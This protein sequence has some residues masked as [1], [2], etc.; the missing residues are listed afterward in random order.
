[1]TALIGFLKSLEHQLV[2][3]P[4]TIDASNTQSSESKDTPSTAKNDDGDIVDYPS[5]E[6]DNGSSF[7]SFGRNV[8]SPITHG[9][10]PV[11]QG[12][13]EPMR[14]LLFGSDLDAVK[15]LIS[16]IDYPFGA[17]P[18]EVTQE[19][20]NLFSL[21]INQFVQF[22]C[23]K[24]KPVITADIKE[25]KA[26][27][28]EPKELVFVDAYKDAQIPKDVTNVQRQPLESSIFPLGRHLFKAATTAWTSATTL[29]HP[30]PAEKKGKET[31]SP[32]QPD[33]EE[34]F[35]VV[36]GADFGLLPKQTFAH[37]THFKPAAQPS[38]PIARPVAKPVKPT[39]VQPLGKLARQSA[40]PVS[41]TTPQPSNTTVKSRRVI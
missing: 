40:K 33:I 32:G 10:I 22:P 16:F 38:K 9:L 17:L 26:G 31:P 6:E 37:H 21:S 8:L 27:T 35:E 34:E 11:T 36:N 20:I 12:L 41:E 39:S 7:L 25:E 29:L 19:V 23:E 3:L 13:V 1:M 24:Q 15:K 28:D 14:N 5:D 4:D 30:K 18:K 2:N